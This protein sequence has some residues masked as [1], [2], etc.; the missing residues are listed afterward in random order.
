MKYIHI[1]IIS[2]FFNSAMKAQSDTTLNKVINLKEVIYSTSKTQ[3][4]KKN[5]AQEVLI[6][7]KEE[8]QNSS[9]STTADIL[10]QSGKVYVQ[11]S[12]QGGGSI[13]LRGF[14]ASRILM[15][16]DG[17]RMNNIIYRAGHLQNAITVDANMLER[18]ELLNGPASNL[19]GTDALGGVVH[20]YTINPTL[21]NTNRFNLNTKALLRYNTANKGYTGH[22][23]I[24]VGFKKLA[25]LTSI[26]ASVYDDLLSGRN[27]NPFS[28]LP[29]GNRYQYVLS[30][31]GYNNTDSLTTN[32]N[33]YLQI[34]SG[35]SQIDFMEKVLYKPNQ[36]TNHILN[37]QY[38]NTTDIPRYDRL[39][40]IGTTAPLK[41]AEWYYGPQKRFLVAYQLTK[42]CNANIADLM[43][44]GLN[45]QALKESRHDR[46]FNKSF[47][48]N[49]IENVKVIGVNI[50]GEKKVNSHLFTLGFDAQYNTLVS[51]AYKYN[52]IVDTIGK[53]NTRYPDGK[54]RLLQAGI[55]FNH[56]YKFMDNLY[57]NDGFRIGYSSL[58]STLV[59]TQ[60]L[61]HLPYTTIDQ[62]AP[63]Y[64][65]SISLVHTPDDW[66]YSATISTGFRSPNV[67]DLS[68]IFESAAGQLIVPNA[69][70]KPEKTINYELGI[71]R[72]FSNKYVWENQ[73]YYT[74]FID[75]LQLDKFSLNGKD[76]TFYE[77]VN[78]ATYALQN[79]LR[80]YLFGVSTQFKAICSEH[81]SFFAGASYT[82]GRV[83]GVV[84][85]PLDHVPPFMAYVRLKYNYKSVNVE[86]FTNF[87]G[88]K[89]VTDYSPSGEDNL[90]YA[91]VNG[92]PAWF[93]QNIHMSY[94]LPK[95]VTIQCGVDNI[96]DTQY[97][98]FASGINAPGRNFFIALR[99][100]L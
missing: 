34:N 90:Q 76:S 11:K 30:R 91:S 96:L 92:S 42:K 21:S 93:T 85:V 60:L 54:N 44:V 48:N 25:F 82:Y 87:N 52:W 36:T 79:K 70:L 12:Q 45:Y 37:I 17:V 78:T 95:Y 80:A 24:N 27:Q 26:T 41:F 65:G 97:R 32:A 29:I 83:K 53:V 64:S 66:K 46:Q 94:Q 35:Y 33:R 9:Q 57:L 73:V 59:D 55:F 15:V 40:D 47:I 62:K 16:V 19:Y 23:A 43:H 56:R 7:T 75:A 74:D 71:T 2:L 14:E 100:R 72:T 8:I 98:T 39:T 63:T 86:W 28:N 4:S 20:F 67:D 58:H 31:A 1:L 84:D 6:F 69:N 18:I 10:S 99:S 22:A 5:V 88:G 68:K 49:R 38:S 50:D 51:T 81:L 89:K 3:E 77:G 61:V 13:V